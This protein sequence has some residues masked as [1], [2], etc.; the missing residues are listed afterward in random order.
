MIL[1]CMQRESGDGAR[2]LLGNGC[3]NVI[4]K[5]VVLLKYYN[6]CNLVL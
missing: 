2:K 5:L 4:C 6:D 1:V 3:R